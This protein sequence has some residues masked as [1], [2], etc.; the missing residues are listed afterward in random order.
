MDISV[1]MLSYR[2]QKV[3]SSH[4]KL[5]FERRQ[6]GQM[7]YPHLLRHL[8]LP[9]SFSGTVMDTGECRTRIEYDTIRYDTMN[10]INVRPKADE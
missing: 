7:T 5:I 10:Y 1:G 3:A 6:E 2:Y 9:R 8:L 4:I